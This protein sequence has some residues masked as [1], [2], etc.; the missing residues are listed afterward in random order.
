MF[1]GVCGVRLETAVGQKAWRE[2]CVGK[3]LPDHATPHALRHSFATHLMEG[4]ADLRVIQD[5]L[6]HVSL[7]TTQRYT[8]ADEARLMQVWAGAHPRAAGH[9]PSQDA[10]TTTGKNDP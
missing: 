2:W 1:G 5:L 10:E 4:G 7:S 3:G 9:G 8:L 6:G